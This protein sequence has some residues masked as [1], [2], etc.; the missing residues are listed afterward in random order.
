MQRQ[1]VSILFILLINVFF[2]S[3]TCFSRSQRLKLR[4]TSRYQLQNRRF[5][6]IKTWED[7]QRY[8]L[9]QVKRPKVEEKKDNNIETKDKFIGELTGGGEN[10]D[11]DDTFEF[12][13]KLVR[14]TD[15]DNARNYTFFMPNNGLWNTSRTRNM[16]KRE[17]RKYLRYHVFQGHH[18]ARTV[19]DGG[20]I[21]SLGGNEVFTN[22]K[23]GLKSR[24]LRF[25]V[26]GAEVTKRNI[27]I[28]NN[29]IHITEGDIYPSNA[30][31]SPSYSLFEHLK[32]SGRH[33]I[34][35]GLLEK[36]KVFFQFP[37][38]VTFFA[39]Y[40]GAFNSIPFKVKEQLLKDDLS[41]RVFL[42]M[43]FTDFKIIF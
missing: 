15:T 29:L 12:Y 23:Y 36:Y 18:T 42:H 26:Q 22:R 28:G 3:V 32:K 19:Q 41:T 20:T 25:W 35:L 10:T 9:N 7:F 5:T 33:N 11:H 21:L 30:A 31:K 39:P 17:S 16:T 6:R 43:Y 38:G 4:E 37:H 2:H 1:I 14:S 8:C 34:I 40:D 13:T 24:G 27:W